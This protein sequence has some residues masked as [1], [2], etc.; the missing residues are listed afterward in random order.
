MNIKTKRMLIIILGICL[1]LVVVAVPFVITPP[2]LN[3][4]S[5]NNKQVGV[6]LRPT[7]T[8][9]YSSNINSNKATVTIKDTTK[10]IYIPKIIKT[11]DSNK[12]IVS[13]E[14]NG[15]LFPNSEYIITVTPYSKYLSIKGE[16]NII[17]FKTR[18]LK[19][20]EMLS[21]SMTEKIMSKEDIFEDGKVKGFEFVANMPIEKDKFT[22]YQASMAQD[23]RVNILVSYLNGGTREDL[24]LWLKQGG[25]EIDKIDINL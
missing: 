19:E 24:L 4:S 5:I 15:Y 6:D 13:F 23:G 2:V 1:V 21:A 25:T 10:S 17:S 18:D 7:I 20:T 14:N 11:V 3:S 8:L 16:K 12:I 9:S 22:I